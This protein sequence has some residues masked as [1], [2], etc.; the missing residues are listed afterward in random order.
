M[1]EV[2]EKVRES[3]ERLK[4][5]YGAHLELRYLNRRFCLFE[6]TSKWDPELGKPRKITRYLG[7]IEDDGLMVPARHRAK[8][9]SIKEM[10]RQY[11]EKLNDLEEKEKRGEGASA[12]TKR[13]KLDEN[14]LALL[15]VLSMNPRLTYQRMS[16]ITGINAQS[17]PYAIRRLEKQLD[18]KYTM[19]IEPSKIGF[20][21]YVILAKFLK[22]W[23]DVEALKVVLAKERRIQLAMLTKGEYDLM[24]FC[25][26]ETNGRLADVLQRVR[27][28]PTLIGVESVWYTTPV[29]VNYGFS[30]LRKEFFSL[31]EE[32]IWHRKKGGPRPSKLVRDSSNPY[33][34]ITAGSHTSRWPPMCHLPKWPV[35]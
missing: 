18:I 27:I 13:S 29:A 6:A 24:I 8:K 20:F 23:P 9:E 2:P 21:E 17:I 22:G 34:G 26:A 5:A 10:E 4:K 7:W 19:T 33:S 32:R 14:D 16:E 31:L 15:K 3:L 25:V 30:L 12:A 28:S 11:L 1:K 35:A